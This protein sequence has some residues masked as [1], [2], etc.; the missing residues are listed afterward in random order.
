M[1]HKITG[2]DTI[3]VYANTSGGITISQKGIEEEDMIYFPPHVAERIIKAIRQCKNEVI[4]ENQITAEICP[5]QE[6]Q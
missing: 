5:K 4:S 3:E 2:F 1:E 6:D